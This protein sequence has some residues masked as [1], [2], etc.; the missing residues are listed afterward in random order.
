[1]EGPDREPSHYLLPG[2]ATE[3]EVEGGGLREGVR[4]MSPVQM[5]LVNCS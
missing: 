4:A 2:A 5:A 3:Q 1:M